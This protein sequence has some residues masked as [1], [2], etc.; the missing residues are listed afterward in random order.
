MA[1][2]RGIQTQAA[3]RGSGAPEPE[4]TPGAAKALHRRAEPV[5]PTPL[6]NTAFTI[7]WLFIAAV[8]LALLF[9]I[10]LFVGGAG[11]RRRAWW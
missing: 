9:L 2:R 6:R 8:I 11:G 1:V 10:N 7:R 3:R 4:P 5:R